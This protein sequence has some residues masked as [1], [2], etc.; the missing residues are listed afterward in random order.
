[1]VLRNPVK[2]VGIGGNDYLLHSFLFSSVFL[3]RYAFFSLASQGKDMRGYA[4]L[5]HSDC[6]SDMIVEF[7]AYPIIFSV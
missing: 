2:Q 6:E 4:P 7:I 3:H 1:M 5:S